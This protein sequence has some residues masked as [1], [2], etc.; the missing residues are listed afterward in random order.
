MGFEVAFTG[1]ALG[2]HIDVKVVPNFF[3]EMQL[4]GSEIKNG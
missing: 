3:P 1:Y 4:P 2:V